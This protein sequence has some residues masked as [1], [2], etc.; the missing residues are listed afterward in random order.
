M[1]TLVTGT[2]IAL[3][4][5][6]FATDFS[7]CSHTAQL[8]AMTLA[9]QYGATLHIAH[10]VPPENLAYL[11]PEAWPVALQ[12][13]NRY[14]KESAAQLEVELRDIQHHLVTPTGEVKDELSRIVEREKIDLLVLG[15]HGRTG[16]RKLLAGSVAE[17]AFRS[18]AC[19]VLT[20]GPNVRFGPHGKVEFHHILFATDFSEDSLAALPY[21]ISL[22]EEDQALLTVLNVIEHPSTA[23][24][25]IQTEKSRRISRL[26]ELVR[27][28]D[29]P[30]CHVECLVEFGG[31]FTS[32]TNRIV[33]VAKERA[34]NLIVLG[35]RR[36][37]GSGAAV[38]HLTSTTAQHVV[39]VAE[40]PVLTVRRGAEQL[41]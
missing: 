14:V 24:A 36:T 41:I 18:L 30:W 25:D 27:P 26:K 34:A 20:V 29:C 3:K 5:I 1:K 12:M 32:P 38:T 31:E 16:V 6:L 8:Y 17:A 28:E 9:K 39:A 13:T 4:N 10:V 21:A 35:V 40:C 23:L 33:E 11:P 15:T 7:A 19:A 22:A 37:H 2:R